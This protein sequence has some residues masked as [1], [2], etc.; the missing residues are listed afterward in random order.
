MKIQILTKTFDYT[1]KN[2]IIFPFL[3][4]KKKINEA[5][6]FFDIKTK[7]QNLKN[8]DIIILDSK[9][10]RLDWLKHHS[11][12]FDRLK[13]LKNKCN[14]LVYYD[15]TD[16]TA[17]IKSEI[18]DYVDEYWKFQILKDKNQYK[19]KFYGGRIF[20]N[21]YHENFGVED[22]DILIC[23]PLIDKDLNKIKVAWNFGLSD[24]STQSKI[25][26]YLRKKLIFSYFFNFKKKKFQK[27]NMI[28]S[29]HLTK[30]ILAKLLLFKEKLFLKI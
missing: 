19:K 18:F 2:A 4:F 10:F 29:A 30:V 15:T 6:I 21:Y 12:I 5:S 8:S 16:S 28:F 25:L 3:A 22:Q 20:T 1:D 7:F 26:F 13:E 17:I 27:R 9:Y 14:K 11:N 24:F 23:N